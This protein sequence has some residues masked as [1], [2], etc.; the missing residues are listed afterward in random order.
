MKEKLFL[1]GSFEMMKEGWTKL[2][3]S[4]EQGKKYFKKISIFN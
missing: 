1:I 2:P 3:T 4:F